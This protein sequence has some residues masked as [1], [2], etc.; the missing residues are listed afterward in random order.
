LS[1]KTIKCM[2]NRLF[3]Y[4]CRIVVNGIRATFAPWRDRLT[5]VIGLVLV[6]GAV[7][8][9]FADRSWTVAAWACLVAGGI[10]GLTV[11]RLIATRLAF[12]AFDG[13]LAA[14]A[15]RLPT[16]QRYMIAWYAIG[17]AILAVVTLVARP[18][19][20]IASL[21][22]YTAGALIGH[23]MFGFAVPGLAMVNPMY[24][25]TIRSWVQR[26]HAGVI[27]A[28]IL[29]LSLLLLTNFLG[30][31]AIITVAG[32]EAAMLV[33]ALTVV[34]DGIVR[35]LTIAGYSSRRIIVR[36]ARGAMLF[37]GV[38]GPICAFAF[39]AIVAGIVVAVSTAALLLL[40][41]RIL[42]YRLHGKR[43][44]DFLVSI[45]VALLLL[46]AFFMPHIV[47]LVAIAVFG[48]LQR[49]AAAK[50]WMLA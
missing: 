21:P 8:A 4:D 41:M 35:F 1:G 18:S 5:A 30:V 32:I 45:L 48:Q 16:R 17:F 31:D 34:D 29:T 15:L 47:P 50:A 23:G 33:L 25:R 36:Q 46:A 49:R 42:A 38:A 24:G 40:A 43:T 22:G 11:G 19:L 20:V 44:A 12:H 27:S 9:W 28:A 39:G 7:R 26:P 10:V 13:P 2:D 14:D 3:H 37:L 6:I